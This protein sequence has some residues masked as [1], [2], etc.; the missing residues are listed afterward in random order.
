MPSFRP[1]I[2]TFK[3]ALN[4]AIETNSSEIII[5]DDNSGEFKD[6]EEYF[7][8][9]KEYEKNERFKVFYNKE[10]KGRFLN[11][12]FALTQAT[13]KYV[14][15]LD[16]DDELIPNEFNKINEMDFEAD[17]LFT[18]YHFKNSLKNKKK[19][20]KWNIFNGSVIYKRE[21]LDGIDLK[22]TPTNFFGDIIFIMH[23][24]K[25]SNSKI[26]YVN[27]SPYR[28]MIIGSTTPSKLLA[29]S[30]DWIKGYDWVKNNSVINE[31]TEYTIEKLDIFYEL[32][33]IKL[34]Q[35]YKKNKYKY[36]KSFNLTP[37]I[38]KKIVSYFTF[39]V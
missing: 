20:K 8:I 1:D 27:I 38:V 6:S 33:M 34:K 15:K 25:Q 10:N 12:H 18:R 23:I 2:K 29:K 13:Q 3:R 37:K 21:S 30:S 26:E 14:K 28:Y 22:D 11:S 31:N 17:M 35:K 32:M 24:A 39:K 9:L 4:T 16:V 36:F 5:V 7:E 19:Y